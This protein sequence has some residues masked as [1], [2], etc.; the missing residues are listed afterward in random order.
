[1]PRCIPSIK[2]TCYPCCSMN[3]FLSIIDWPLY[4]IQ[5]ILSI[6]GLA[7]DRCSIIPCLTMAFFGWA[8]RSD[9]PSNPD[10]MSSSPC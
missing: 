9:W 2:R 8:D 10:V 4:A 3:P 1:M 6:A 5:P 7:V